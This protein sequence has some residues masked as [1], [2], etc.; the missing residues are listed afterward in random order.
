[1]FR[2]HFTPGL[3]VAVCIGKFIRSGSGTG[4]SFMNMKSVK[5]EALPCIVRSKARNI[6]TDAKRMFF[7][8]ISSNSSKI[9]SLLSSNRSP[10]LYL[11]YLSQSFSFRYWML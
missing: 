9:F 10:L 8:D 2:M 6:S 3:I 7:Y 11:K 1:M 5:A 4:A